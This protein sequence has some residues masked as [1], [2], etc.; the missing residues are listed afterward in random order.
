MGDDASIP[1]CQHAP[2]ERESERE[3]THR[4]IIGIGVDRHGDSLVSRLHR[5]ELC[6]EARGLEALCL[7]VCESTHGSEG[8]SKFADFSED[9]LN[10]EVNHA[11]GRGSEFNLAVVGGDRLS[12]R[13]GGVDTEVLVVIHKAESDSGK[14]TLEHV[15]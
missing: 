13:M 10:A 12:T 14:S 11:L 6:T 15:L 2:K 5:E 3:R 4:V 8:L 9:G 7:D 1:A